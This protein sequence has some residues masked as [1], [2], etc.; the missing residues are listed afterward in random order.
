MTTCCVILYLKGQN[1][2]EKQ[3]NENYN[4]AEKQTKEKTR[5]QELFSRL[6]EVKMQS[7]EKGK[8]NITYI[9]IYLYR[10]IS[11]SVGFQQ[12]THTHP[13]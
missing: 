9:S 8:R 1:D 4:D 3:T 11:R 6:Y 2:A 10:G 7:Y 5:K 12:D 13:H